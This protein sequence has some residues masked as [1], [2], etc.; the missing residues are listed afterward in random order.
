[1]AKRIFDFIFSFTLLLLLSPFLL[2]A[3]LAIKITDGGNVFYMAPR[4]GLRGKPFRMFKFR[5]MV[6]NADKMG[7]SSTTANDSRLTS[8][9]KFLRKYK[10]DELPQLIN[11]LIGEMSFV[12]PR[13]QIKWA[14]DL[15]TE[16][17]KRVL[18]VKPG[19]TD[20]ASLKFHN[21]GEILAGSTDPD[22]TYM[23]KIH[24]HKM[25]LALE[26]VNDHSLMTDIKIIFL[27]F[28]RIFKK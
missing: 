19:I 14:V 20:Y 17:E 2:F 11:V 18:E 1:M 6:L 23:E 8:T 7:A 5:S 27:T 9:G 12:G 25:K 10:L 3:A 13:P 26:Y 15:Y 24:P 4:I 22:K 16:E 21:E 28:I